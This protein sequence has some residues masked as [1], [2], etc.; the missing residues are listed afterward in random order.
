[1]LICSIKS[2]TLFCYWCRSFLSVG[3]YST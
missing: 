2:H 3:L 1:L